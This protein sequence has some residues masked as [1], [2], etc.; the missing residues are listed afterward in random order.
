MKNSFFLVIPKQQSNALRLKEF[1]EKTLQHWINELP[2][3]NPGLATRLIHDFLA[4]FNSL[5]MPAQLRLSALELLRPSVLVIE[6]YL[7]SRLITTGFPKEEADKKILA[8]LVSIQRYNT[9]GYWAVLKELTQRD[10]G[11]FQGKNIAVAIQRCIKGLS[12][13]VISHFIMGMTVPDW[14]WIDLH[15]LYRLSVKTKKDTTKV[16]NDAGQLNK[17]SSPEECYRQIL[18]LSLTDPTGLMQKEVLLVYKFIETMDDLV[19]LKNQPIAG[20]QLQC[21]IQTDEDL[22]PFFDNSPAKQD[23]SRQYL[24]LTKLHKALINKQKLGSTSEARFSSVHVLKNDSGKPTLELLDY[25]EQRWSGV[26][27]QGAALFPDRLDRYVAI[28]LEATHDL[29]MSQSMPAPKDL[30]FLMQTASERLLSCNFNKTGAL[31]VGSLVSF[32]KTDIA[33]HR[34]SL[35]IVSKLVVEKQS[36]KIS[37]GLQLL[38]R[39]SLP[40]TYVHIDTGISQKGLFYGIKEPDG[41]KGFLLTDN[42]V[43]KND[44]IIRMTLK[45]EDLPIILGNRRNVGLGYWQFECRRLAENAK[46]SLPAKKGY[47][48][49]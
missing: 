8:V 38:A 28:G 4:E 21:V 35:G 43:L 30:E 32:R 13:V 23:A 45:N 49:I 17:G 6:D 20:Q 48:F 44:D 36:G 12:S 5:E 15:S 33:E 37:V 26:E 42:F 1:E 41:E 10:A 34:R 29:L 22:P 25:L 24:D 14:V 18:L 9:T 27:L 2:T 19:S 40:V 16:V 39:Q 11:W 31:S 7:R 46:A 3:A 47:D